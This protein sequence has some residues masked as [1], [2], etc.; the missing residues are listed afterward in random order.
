M[1]KHENVGAAVHPQLMSFELNVRR[2]KKVPNYFITLRM[3][4]LEVY[5]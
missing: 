2:K 1:G 3:I 4:M 5:M